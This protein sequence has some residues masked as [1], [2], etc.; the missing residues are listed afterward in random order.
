[1]KPQ[2]WKMIKDQLEE[3]LRNMDTCDEEGTYQE[4]NM[5]N[6]TMGW[7]CKSEGKLKEFNQ[8]YEKICISIEYEELG[9]HFD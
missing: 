1:M 4:M 3:N 2:T 8:W 9:E 5:E 7:I 6:E